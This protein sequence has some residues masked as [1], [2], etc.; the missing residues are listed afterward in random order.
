MSDTTTLRDHSQPCEHRQA[1]QEHPAAVNRE[2]WTTNRIVAFN[3]YRLRKPRLRTPVFTQTELAVLMQSMG[4]NWTVHTCSDAEQAR[5]DDNG[6]RFSPDEITALAFIFHVSPVTLLLPPEGIGVRWGK[7]GEGKSTIE[8]SRARY[9]S[10]VLMIPGIE[11]TEQLED[12]MR[13][14]SSKPDWGTLRN[15][16]PDAATNATTILSV[17]GSR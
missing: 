4:Q 11:G 8:I 14:M 13:E 5:K 9:G 7:P 6:R 3:L 12:T 1:F 10:D 17:C 15:A 2:A 16:A